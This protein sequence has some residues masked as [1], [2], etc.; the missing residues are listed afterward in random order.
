[1]SSLDLLLRFSLKKSASVDIYIFRKSS[2]DCVVVVSLSHVLADLSVAAVPAE[3]RPQ[4]QITGSHKARKTQLAGRRP[5][6]LNQRSVTPLYL[7]C[8]LPLRSGN[9][10][11]FIAVFTRRGTCTS[12]PLVHLSASGCVGG[13]RE[14]TN[15]PANQTFRGGRGKDSPDH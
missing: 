7:L 15:P 6:T 9:I 1:M 14:T 13:G 3:E 8:S 10:L 5:P 2:T 11:T 4:G 12:F